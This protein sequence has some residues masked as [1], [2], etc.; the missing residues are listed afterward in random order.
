MKTQE[1][2]NGNVA[3]VKVEITIS[4]PAFELPASRGRK[5]PD[6]YLVQDVSGQYPQNHYDGYDLRSALDAHLENG[7]ER[8]SLVAVIYIHNHQY[9]CKFLPLAGKWTDW[10]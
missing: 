3:T 10:E 2:L 8:T 4:T 5:Y 1:A 9:T 6:H 7:Y